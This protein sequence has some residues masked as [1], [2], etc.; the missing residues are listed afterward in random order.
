MSKGSLS[1]LPIILVLGLVGCAGIESVP[2]PVEPAS[3]SPI[4][5]ETAEP[6]PEPTPEPVPWDGPTDGTWEYGDV[7]F[8]ETLEVRN[9]DYRVTVLGLPEF[10]PLEDEKVTVTGTFN[11]ERF[12]DRGFDDEILDDLRF[13]FTPG[14]G[15][16]APLSETYGLNPKVECEQDAIAV[17]ETAICRVSF[18]APAVEMENFSWWISRNKVAA[19]PGQTV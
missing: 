11:V 1:A 6:T 15:T 2:E 10:G 9:S 14:A 3:T 12:Q 18:N 8:G 4:P 16:G 17:G 19:W 7:G 5:T 13:G